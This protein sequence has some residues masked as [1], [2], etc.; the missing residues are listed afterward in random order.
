MT[1]VG[2]SGNTLIEE[3]RSHGGLPGRIRASLVLSGTTVGCVFT[4]YLHGGSVM[5]R[6]S[7][8][9]NVGHGTYASFVGALSISHGTGRYRHAQGS[10]SIYGTLNR[11]DDSA[12]VQAVGT[13][14]Y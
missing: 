7:A 12:I 5:G 13:M 14:S 4:V 1:L 11:N 9:L 10:G 2:G 6:G 3:G 8:K